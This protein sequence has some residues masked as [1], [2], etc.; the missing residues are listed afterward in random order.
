MPKVGQNVNLL[1]RRRDR[2][3]SLVELLVVVIIIALIVAIAVPN[4]SKARMK[5]NE[6]S[7]LA[8]VRTIQTAEVMYSNAYP[9]VG[10]AGNLADLGAN[11]TNCQSTSK[12]NA[13]L[14]MD[15]ALTSGLKSGYTFEVVGDGAAPARGYTITATPQSANSSGRCTFIADQSGSIQVTRP[16]GAVTRFTVSGGGGGCGS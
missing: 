12:T 2:G 9:L 16:G 8:S 11:G 15:D 7:A 14:I 4:M 13:C 1:A 6:A 10:F 3:F 5:A